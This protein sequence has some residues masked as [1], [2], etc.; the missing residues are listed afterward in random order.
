MK[1]LV[2]RL[3]HTVFVCAAFMV[4]WWSYDHFIKEVK[5][6]VQ[7]LTVSQIN[8]LGSQFLTLHIKG[9]STKEERLILIQSSFKG[10]T[11]KSETN[12]DEPFLASVKI[13]KFIPGDSDFDIDV[14]QLLNQAPIL[15]QSIKDLRFIGITVLPNR[16]PASIQ[17]VTMPMAYFT[18][19]S[20]QTLDKP[21]QVI[22]VGKT[23]EI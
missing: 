2:M 12:E 8:S 16:D 18:I 22:V 19:D 3:V 21:S 4:G 1:K 6:P 7:D 17:F 5:I 10:V 15:V 23:D 11:I 13:L 9:I 14:T 20:V